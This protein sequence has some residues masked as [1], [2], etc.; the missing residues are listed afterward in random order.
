[1]QAG[2]YGPIQR[3][4]RSYSALKLVF[5]ALF[6]VAVAVIW[7]YQLTAVRP[8]VDCLNKPGGAWNAKTRVCK[9]SRELACE[10]SG[11]WWDPLDK[12]CAKVVSVPSITGR[13]APKGG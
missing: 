8:K 7:W 12:L 5:V 3:P 6:G 13:P 9:V 2:L 4:M 11:G 1:M 10:Q